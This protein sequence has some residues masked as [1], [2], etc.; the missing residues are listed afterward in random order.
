[1]F[2]VKIKF[3]L[4]FNNTL[5]ATVIFQRIVKNIEFF[6]HNN[7]LSKLNHLYQLDKVDYYYLFMPYNDTYDLTLEEALII[8]SDDEITEITMHPDDD[9][10]DDDVGDDDVGDDDV[11]DDDVGNV[12]D[13]IISSI[14]YSICI[15]NTDH[16]NCNVNIMRCGCGCDEL[17]KGFDGFCNPYPNGC[18]KFSL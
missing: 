3:S 16:A 18:I 8:H 14:L 1:M 2:S 5:V 12:V 9:V 10:G 17:H 6:K 4:Y 15:I 11:G 13:D 7:E